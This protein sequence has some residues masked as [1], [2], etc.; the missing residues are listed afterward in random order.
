M[1]GPLTGVR[2]VEL[3][4]LGPVPF[5]GMLLA[6]LGAEVVR[7]DKLPG[8]RPGMGDAFAAT[9]LGRGRRSIALDIRKPEGAEVAAAPAS[10]RP[11]R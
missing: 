2:V 6:D 5:L 4:A 7:V 10:R 3:P 1:P 9:A 8:A 11:T